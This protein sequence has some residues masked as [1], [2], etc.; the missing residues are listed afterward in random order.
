MLVL[1]KNSLLL[2]G[3]PELRIPREAATY[4]QAW[5]H[6][7]SSHLFWP[8]PVGECWQCRL[9]PPAESDRSEMCISLLRQPGAVAPLL[10]DGYIWTGKPAALF[11]QM[12]WKTKDLLQTYKLT[13]IDTTVHEDQCFY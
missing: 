9:S 12:G 2:Q 10:H 11:L 4:I 7:L 13:V 3:T 8:E 6:L 5:K 1:R